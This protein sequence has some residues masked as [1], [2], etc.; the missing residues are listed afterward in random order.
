MHQCHVFVVPLLN[1]VAGAGYG[2]IIPDAP[3]AESH[4]RTQEISEAVGKLVEQYRCNE[5]GNELTSN[6]WICTS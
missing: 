6:Q 2:S 1:V 5:Q 4:A 3:H